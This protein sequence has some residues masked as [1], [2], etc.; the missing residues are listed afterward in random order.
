MSLG[1]F[2]P[3]ANLRALWRM[4]NTNDSSGNG[5]H[6]SAYG[7]PTFTAGRFGK[8]VNIS[9]DNFVRR[10]DAC[11]MNYSANYTVACWV[12][13]SSLAAD[14]YIFDLRSSGAG[15]YAMAKI[16]ADGSLSFLVGGNAVDTGVN[17]ATGIYYFIGI[18]R[19]GSTAY[20][21]VNGTPCG[22]TSIGSTS[23]SRNQ[24]YIGYRYAT[25]G[26]YMQGQVDELALFQEYKPADWWRK[27]YALSRGLLC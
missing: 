12:R 15:N 14:D 5:Y 1:E 2:W 25:A 19:S 9:T 10:E 23:N 21:Y 17:L 3:Q 16:D 26:S 6:L 27:Q 22:S 4:E 13:F 11:G 24:A 18:T 8:A 20:F 7:S